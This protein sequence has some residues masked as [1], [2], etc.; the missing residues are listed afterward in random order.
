MMLAKGSFRKA[1]NKKICK[2]FSKTP[3]SIKQ[4]FDFQ[5]DQ[6]AHK[7]TYDLVNNAKPRHVRGRGQTPSRASTVCPNLVRRST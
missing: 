2:F 5:G 7:F 4:K 6:S 1:K 3:G